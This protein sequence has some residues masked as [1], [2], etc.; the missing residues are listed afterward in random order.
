M[1]PPKNCRKNGS[2]NKTVGGLLRLTTLD[3]EMFT[4]AGMAR[5]TIGAKLTERPLIDRGGVRG[6]HENRNAMRAG[7]VVAISAPSQQRDDTAT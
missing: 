7:S 3:D 1:R 4:T 5:F 2:S 6:G